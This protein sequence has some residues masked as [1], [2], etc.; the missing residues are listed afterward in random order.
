[1]Q[2]DP[3]AGLVEANGAFVGALVEVDRNLGP[4]YDSSTQVDYEF[5]VEAALKGDIRDTIVV[6]S[7]VDGASCGFERRSGSGWGSCWIAL[8]TIGRETS[9]GPSTPTPSLPQLEARHS[10]SPDRPLT[11]SPR[12]PWRGRSGGSQPRR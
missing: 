8:A 2:P 7:A 11:S 6:K 9:A 5:E 12:S 1:M 3:Y 4:V 10:R